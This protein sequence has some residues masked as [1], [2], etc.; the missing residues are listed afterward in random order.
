M[1]TETK[2]DAMLRRF[3]NTLKHS[4]INLKVELGK[5]DTSRTGRLDKKV[6]TRAMKQMS[7]A[8]SDDEIDTIFSAAETPD[9]MV[10][11]MNLITK[12]TNALKSK[13]MPNF[14]T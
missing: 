4:G 8:L 7:I 9:H 12:V 13:P 5:F 1:A 11:I 2:L 14:F 10:D 3:A 6:F